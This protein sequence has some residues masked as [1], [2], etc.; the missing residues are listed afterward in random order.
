MKALRIVTLIALGVSCHL[1]KL[2]NGG[3]SAASPV[4]NGTPV[5]LMFS[6]QPSSPRAGP[7]G[8]VQVSVV[9]SAGQ[10]V[11]GVESTTVA[12]ALGS[13]P[14][15]GTLRGT[16]TAHPSRGVATFSDLS[17]DRAVSG[18]TLTAVAAGL[19][20]VTSDTFTVVPGPAAQ[21]TFT[22]EPSDVSQ[23]GVVSPP[24]VVTAFDSLGNK[25]TTF[26]GVVSLALR[27]NGN[28]V[29]GALSGNST[30]AV[31]GVATFR[32]LQINNAGAGGY[33][34]AAAFGTAAPVAES[35]PFNV[36]PPGPPP[37]QPGDLAI[38]TATSGVDLPSGYTLTVDGNAAGSIG[39]SVSLTI[40]GV[41]AGDHVVGLG[42]VPATCTVTS[43]NPLTVNVPAA[44]TGRGDFVVT[45]GAPPS[46]PP[47]APGPYLLFTDEPV[48]TQAGQPM[49]AVRV[50][51]YDASGNQDRTYT[52]DVTLSIGF[53][54]SGG[55]LT[56]G[57]TITMDLGLGGVVE[58]D[59]ISI[60]KPGFGYTLHATSPGLREA[61][62]D[63]L[64]IT[65]GP[66]PSPN[67]AS[68][69]GFFTQP[70]TTRAGD[71]IAPVRIGALGSGGVATAYSGPIWISLGS[72]PTGATLSGTRHLFAVNGFVTF[73]DL[74]IDKPGT[75]YTLRATAWPLNYKASVL[76]NVTAP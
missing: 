50:T 28:T 72:N 64:D 66:P 40:T 61:F 34:L 71:L 16:T 74:R 37:P 43:A 38:T 55:S 32:N 47:P 35:A 53:N 15:G 48:I 10:P 22:A 59:R 39:T 6:R 24:V 46:P 4:S 75:G 62:S 23:G 57:G 65:A 9:D 60:D 52:G 14:A 19:P 7:I 63:P 31:A 44:G 27:Q 33:T 54:P 36:K 67:G 21:L 73:S 2:L 20:T 18:Y 58:W 17:L 1:D 3:G 51:V 56:G 13:N 12:I 70:G 49:P 29:N 69:L 30:A 41:A 42:G 8:P 25:A 11:A 5:A 26:T 68:G 76:F 45:C